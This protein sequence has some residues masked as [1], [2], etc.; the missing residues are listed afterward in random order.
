MASVKD[1]YIRET[2]LWSSSIFKEKPLTP[3]RKQICV[4]LRCLRPFRWQDNVDEMLSSLFNFSPTILL[5]YPTHFLQMLSANMF[6]RTTQNYQ[7]F[8]FVDNISN[9]CG[10]IGKGLPCG[11]LYGICFLYEER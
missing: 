10:I 7:P 2:S 9:L 3:K 8:M 4:L 6:D 1:L 11:S 5:I